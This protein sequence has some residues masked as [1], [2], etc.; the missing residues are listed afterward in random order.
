MTTRQTAFTIDLN[1]IKAQMCATHYILPPWQQK[2]INVC[3]LL[4]RRFLTLL[5]KYPK[6]HLVP[7]KIIDEFWHAHI[8][9][10]QKY[11]RDCIAI[12]GYYI[13]HHPANGN[14]P[15]INKLETGFQ[16]TC[17]LYQQEFSEPLL[18]FI[19]NQAEPSLIT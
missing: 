15:D 14:N 9:H 6:E 8:L 10:T 7:S 2:D 12:A 13:H 18:I 19:P 16:K 5:I 4:Y 11:H 1:L 17:D 3:E